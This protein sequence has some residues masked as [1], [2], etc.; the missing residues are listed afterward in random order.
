MQWLPPVIQILADTD[1]LRSIRSLTERNQGAYAAFH[2][3]AHK[4]ADQGCIRLERQGKEVLA[5]AASSKIPALA[6]ALCNSRMARNLDTLFRG[7]RDQLLWVLHRIGD[8]ATT[9][10]V[11]TCSTRTVYNAIQTFSGKGIVVKGPRYH[12][13]P[14]HAELIELLGELD[15]L[16]AEHR[17]KQLPGARLMW[18]LGP[19]MLVQTEHAPAD[20]QFAGL[21][22][23]SQYD[24]AIQTRGPPLYY[25]GHRTLTAADAILQA[26]AAVG[27]ETPN[28]AV[29]PSG[30]RLVGQEFNYACL[31][32]EKEQ[33]TDIWVKSDLYFGDELPARDVVEYVAEQSDEWAGFI[34]WSEHERLRKLYGINS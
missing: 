16:R 13:H 6:R 24:I 4:L 31:L 30:S 14:S 19:E 12:I 32:W 11:M 1:Q 3:A 2:K 28:P 10:D 22:A 26:L 29:T 18:H 15:R 25:L 34:P 20:A 7:H 17:A 23:F 27:Y 9:A 21:D 33:P 5:V 8:V